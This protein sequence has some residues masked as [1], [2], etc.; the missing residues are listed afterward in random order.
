MKSPSLKQQMY[1]IIFIDD[2]SRMTWI[3]LKEKSEVFIV[4]K[5]FKALVEKQNGCDIIIFSS[6]CFLNYIPCRVYVKIAPIYLL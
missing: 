3:F 2:F 6:N 5:R 1:F 4:F